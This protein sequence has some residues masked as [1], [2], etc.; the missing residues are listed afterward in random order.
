MAIMQLTSEL[1]QWVK[2]VALG[3]LVRERSLIQLCLAV[4]CKT[5]T[6]VMFQLFTSRLSHEFRVAER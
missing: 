1:F 4:K 5:H 3:D 6:R 2:H